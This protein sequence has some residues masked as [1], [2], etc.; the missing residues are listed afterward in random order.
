MP[1]VRPAVHFT[2]RHGWINDPH[3]LTFR[4]GLYHLFF[5]AIPSARRWQP[6]SSWGHATSPDLL[7]WEERP[8]VLEPG[9][10]DY[11]C[12]SGS[13]C[14]EPASAPTAM[15]YTSVDSSRLDRGAVRIAR[16]AGDDWMQW[17][18]GQIVLGPPSDASITAFRDPHVFWD[19]DHWRMLVGAGHADGR[20]AVL[21]F[22]STD[23]THWDFDG[24]LADSANSPAPP[25]SQQLVWECPQLIQ[26]SGRHVLVVSLQAD[27]V[28]QYTAAAVGD[29]A[30]GR[31]QV[32][33]WE[34]LTFGPGHYA[35]SCFL[36]AD[37]DPCAIF[38]L[39]DVAGHDWKGALSIPYRMSLVAGRLV[40]EPHPNL[41]K[42]RPDGARISGFSW[43][44][45]AG[46]AVQL[47]V[48]STQDRPVVDLI[49][50][51]DHVTVATAAG[52]VSAPRAGTDIDVLI[53]GAV[54]EV[55]TGRC[56]VGL[57]VPAVEGL[58]LPSHQISPWW[59]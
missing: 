31:M 18:K 15:Y 44:P 11:G 14:T 58:A 47:H 19:V 50:T 22:T 51:T 35:A 30:D 2:P 4:E 6:W 24:Q 37:R 33:H 20:A 41:K 1:E 57:P 48:P 45:R 16:A 23:Q 17:R 25:R 21:T 55:N 32:E 7:T 29:Y 3:G 9:D 54:L 38:W 46:R 36:D 8:L 52:T 5:Q 28:G 26:V 56:L 53:D 43:R 42:A 27:G 34:Q 13:V 40:L 39:R 59:S 10:G 12:W 49:A